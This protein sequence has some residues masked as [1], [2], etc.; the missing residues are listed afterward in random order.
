V[1][2]P[3]ATLSGLKKKIQDGDQR[4]T[5]VQQLSTDLRVS[6]KVSEALSTNI[7]KVTYHLYKYNTQYKS[8]TDKV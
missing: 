3:S 8:A 7:A 4:S 1:A 2:A 6:R 5:I